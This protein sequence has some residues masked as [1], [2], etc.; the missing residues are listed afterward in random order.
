MYMAVADYGVLEGV[1]LWLA[2]VM[3]MPI[4]AI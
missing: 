2:S 4:A 3:K 1:A